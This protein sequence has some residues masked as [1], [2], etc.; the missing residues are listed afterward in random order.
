MDILLI[1]AGSVML[2][3]EQALL[4]ISEIFND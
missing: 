2:V 1:L 4:E 3:A